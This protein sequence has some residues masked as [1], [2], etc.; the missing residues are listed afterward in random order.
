MCIL[1]P[2]ICGTLGLT[3]ADPSAAPRIDPHYL[4]DPR[5]LALMKKGARMMEQMMNAPPLDSWR[6]TK[7]YDHDG[8]DA[9][10]EADIRS[11]ADTI[12]HPVGICRMGRDDMAVVDP[13]GL[14]HGV[15]GLRVVEASIM[16]RLVG[17]SPNAPTIMI[18]EKIAGGM[19]GVAGQVS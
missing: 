14:L 17:G 4:S 16:P 5:D 8:S 10:L 11:R 7:L 3:S 1:R 19:R 9:S 15:S 6:G 12:Y 18:A 13:A 2:H